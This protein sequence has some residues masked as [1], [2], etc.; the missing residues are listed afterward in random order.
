MIEFFYGT[1]CRMNETLLLRVEDLDLD[2]RQ[3]RV[4][5]KYGRARIEL[6]TPSAETARRAYLNGRRSGF[7]LQEEPE[8]RRA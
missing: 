7:V 1:G 3:A 5:G 4:I 2:A 6:F 8:S